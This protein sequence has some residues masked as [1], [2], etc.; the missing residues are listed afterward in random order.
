M[1]ARK[2]SS[3]EE[4]I[5][6]AWKL[7]TN[8]GLAALSLLNF[9]VLSGLCYHFVHSCFLTSQYIQKASIPTMKLRSDIK[10]GVLRLVKALGSWSQTSGLQSC[11]HFTRNLFGLK[12]A[13]YLLFESL[14]NP[15]LQST[16]LA[17]HSPQT[18][19]YIHQDPAC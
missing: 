17:R 10:C 14:I 2:A 11:S 7:G 18:G 4:L 12:D 1:Q 19:M 16:G 15:E 3:V 5:L 8:L 6:G 9:T 13:V